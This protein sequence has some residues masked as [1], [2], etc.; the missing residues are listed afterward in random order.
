MEEKYI[1]QITGYQIIYNLSRDNVKLQQPLIV[2]DLEEFRKELIQRHEAQG[3]NLSYVEM[4][5]E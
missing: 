1:Y 5:T 4:K 3:V 2:K